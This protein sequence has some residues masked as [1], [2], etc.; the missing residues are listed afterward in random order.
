MGGVFKGSHCEEPGDDHLSPGE[1]LK[2]AH[3][4]KA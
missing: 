4:L 3:K 1:I 2:L